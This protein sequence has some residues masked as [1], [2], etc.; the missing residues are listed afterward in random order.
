MKDR[1]DAIR[2]IMQVFSWLDAA[3][4][5]SPENYNTTKSFAADLKPDERLL[6]HWL[7]YITDRMTP[8][9]RVWDVGGY[10]LSRIVRDYCRKRDKSVEDILD[11]FRGKRDK[12]D[13]VRGLLR[14]PYGDDYALPTSAL[15]EGDAVFVPRYPPSDLGRIY[16]TLIV[17]DM[18]KYQRNIGIFMAEALRTQAARSLCD[19]IKALVVTL[20]ALTYAPSVPRSADAYVRTIVTVKDQAE[21]FAFDEG[22]VSA[23]FKQI[24]FGD[25]KRL[26]CSVR[27]YL[28]S[29]QFNA[30]LV[31]ALSAGGADPGRW[32]SQ[33]PQVLSALEVL[34][35][36]GDVWN[37]RVGNL[38]QPYAA[39]SFGSKSI[40]RLVRHLHD[41][42]SRDER[43]DWYP[44]QLDVSFDFVPRMCES[45][46][47]DICP[48]GDGI[49]K[50]C[51]RT[52][53]LLCPVALTTCG[54]RYE[55]EGDCTVAADPA[56]G[57]CQSSRRRAERGEVS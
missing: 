54:Y 3:R 29:P 46:M 11:E 12:D 44:E 6:T 7:C 37:A 51:H 23:R 18:A 9:E 31:E 52:P 32:G 22:H 27:D 2:R 25:R 57:L 17:L 33:N 14:Y 40:S 49:G 53:G 50:L 28:K 15:R 39:P 21:G 42:A 41:E 13:E 34:E 5:S 30:D 38:L 16:H 26:W 8:F 56:L 43:P 19:G 35:L 24:R 4:W 48:F 20:D 55:C 36:P 45:R 47:C 1:K 10:V